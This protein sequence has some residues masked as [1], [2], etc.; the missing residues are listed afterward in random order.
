M[1]DY[2]LL[3]IF[4]GRDEDYYKQQMW[5]SLATLASSG[6]TP[7]HSVGQL[8][9]YGVNSVVNPSQVHLNQSPGHP[10][11]PSYLHQYGPMVPPDSVRTPC[12]SGIC[13]RPVSPN[14]DPG[15]NSPVTSP[16]RSFVGHPLAV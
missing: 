9:H 13:M 7:G 2:I 5:R 8:S 6:V 16:S 11:R 1:T 12:H 4:V 15:V 3:Y 10:S 14:D